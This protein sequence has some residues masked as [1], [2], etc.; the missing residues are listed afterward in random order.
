MRGLFNVKSQLRAFVE[1][2]EG[3]VTAYSLIVLIGMLALG[4]YAVDVSNVTSRRTHLQ[5]TADAVAHAA[6]LARE[7]GTVEEARA[8]A[9]EISVGNLPE[10]Y[11]GEVVTPEEIIFGHWDPLTE[12]FLPDEDSRSAVYVMAREDSTNGNAVGT[13]MLG[14][15]GFDQWDVSAI[16]VYST[17]KPSC[18][19]D[20]FVAEGRV[21][22][23]SN[24]FYGNGFCIH[25]NTGVKLSQNNTF[26]QGTIVS[27][28]DLDTLQIPAS[29]YT[30]NI[31][32]QEALR[33]GSWNVRIVSR[34]SQVIAG[35]QDP[36]SQ[37]YPSYITSP[38]QITLTNRT[39]AA[40]HL[41]SGR[42]HKLTCSGNQ[43]MRF[44]TGFTLQNVVIITN[45][46]VR[47][48]QGVT[49]INAA[50]VTT[51]TGN[52]SISS[53]SS[54]TLGKGDDCAAG[55]SA[56]LVTMGSIKFAAKLTINGGQLL[57][58]GDIS[59]S[60]QGA[61]AK[62]VQ[63]VAGGE[64]SGTSNMEMIGCGNLQEENLQLNYFRMAY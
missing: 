59:F 34:I 41:T 44:S 20:G 39:V 51:N 27:M 52:Q 17:Y 4:G 54:F 5:I 12:T 48:N 43:D 7:F 29:G 8:A 36:D 63:L 49:L 25:S 33:E 38:T 50:I 3:G 1:G 31:G 42:I 15:V 45:C 24:N 13:F 26:E 9:L 6:I 60:A 32:L 21:D 2:D 55:G 28:A 53:S 56:Q 30:K 37:F 57:A 62:G 22:V 46:A 64:I 11:A 58:K 47:F 61:G 23:Q 16:S 35:M 10:A 40:S 18:L 19:S 14:I